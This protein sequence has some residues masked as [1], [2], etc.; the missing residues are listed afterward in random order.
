M[1]RAACT[2]YPLPAWGDADVFDEAISIRHGELFEGGRPLPLAARPMAE[3]PRA[4][5]YG[6]T[7]RPN[8]ITLQKLGSGRFQTVNSHQLRFLPRFLRPTSQSLSELFYSG[9]CKKPQRDQRLGQA[10]NR[11]TSQSAMH[12]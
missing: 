3:R 5:L 10:G 2:V 9:I 4:N 8:G 12:S 6:A 1:H 7:L 11:I